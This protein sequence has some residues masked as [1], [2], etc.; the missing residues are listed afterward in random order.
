MSHIQRFRVPIGFLFGAAYIYFAQPE[1]SWYVRGLGVSVVGLCFRIW[2]AGHL[3]KFRSLARSGP[4]R[5]TRNPL[6]FGSFLLG[7]G[8]SL[9]GARLWLILVYVLLFFS[10]YFPVMRREER[11]LER[12][13]GEPYRR[14]RKAVSLFVPLP[15]RRSGQDSGAEERNFRWRRVILNREYRASIGF[16]ILAALIFIKMVKL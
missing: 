7:L 11:E 15:S 9:A 3:E 12:Q 1:L 5:Y 2:A 8:F 14:Y 10:V 6:Y 4:Y 16:L 13:Y